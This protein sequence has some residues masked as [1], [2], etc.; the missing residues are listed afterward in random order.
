M[1]D[2]NRMPLAGS[3]RRS[4]WPLLLALVV[5]LVVVAVLGGLYVGK[6]AG[7]GIPVKADGAS[8]ITG[9]PDGQGIGLANQGAKL[10]G[11]DLHVPGKLPQGGT[12]PANEPGAI[13]APGGVELQRPETPVES[14]AVPASGD[15]AAVATQAPVDSVE[16]A[17][18]AVSQ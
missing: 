7:Q 16:S 12:P 11:K 14:A 4:R 10:L 3:A 9:T 15:G 6:G 2:R 13:V 1:T 17:A 5:L 8:D 18:S